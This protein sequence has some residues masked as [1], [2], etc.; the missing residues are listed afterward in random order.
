MERVHGYSSILRSGQNS[1]DEMGE[2][3]WTSGFLIFFLCD[4]IIR[5]LEKYMDARVAEIAINGSCS[6]H[7]MYFVAINC[8]YKVYEMPWTTISLWGWFLTCYKPRKLRAGSCSCLEAMSSDLFL[9]TTWWSSLIQEN[10]K[11]IHVV[12]LL[13]HQIGEF[14]L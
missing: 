2:L 13:R 1:R 11:Q 5:F 14:F 6:W 7:F 3:P 12:Y 8:E 9:G 10:F 4:L